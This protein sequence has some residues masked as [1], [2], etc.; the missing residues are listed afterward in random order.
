M[1]SHPTDIKVAKDSSRAWWRIC[2]GIT[3]VQWRLYV[4]E[5]ECT[6]GGVGGDI[7]HYF[8]TDPM[9]LPR[10]VTLT[11]KSVEHLFL[12]RPSSGDLIM[13]G[14][15]TYSGFCLINSSPT[16]KLLLLK[17]LL[18]VLLSR[19]HKMLVLSVSFLLRVIW[20]DPAM[21][22]WWK[23]QLLQQLFFCAASV[24]CACYAKCVWFKKAAKNQG[25]MMTIT[26]SMYCSPIR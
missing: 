13:H 3:C 24:A 22:Y 21:K 23:I 7:L 26:N 5:R 20:A 11:G 19:N 9:Y 6:F 10:C 17:E 16:N 25:D 12:A 2:G 14:W 1:K 8:I 15:L 18:H 4:W